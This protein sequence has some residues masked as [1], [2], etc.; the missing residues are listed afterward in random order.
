[1][2][3]KKTNDKFDQQQEIVDNVICVATQDT[4][5]ILLSAV[6]KVCPPGDKTSSRAIHLN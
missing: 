1:M 5:I 6:A 2:I 3:K 4:R